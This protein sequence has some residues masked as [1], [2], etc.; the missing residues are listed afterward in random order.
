MLFNRRQPVHLVRRS[1]ATSASVAA[2][3]VTE[4]GEEPKPP[5]ERHKN[6]K[7]KAREEMKSG[8]RTA[9]ALASHSFDVA[10]ELSDA[11]GPLKGVVNGVGYV[12]DIWQVSAYSCD[13]TK[14]IC[15]LIS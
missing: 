10:R 14:P 11:F 4:D 3:E 15:V 8:M 7:K 1:R 13:S 9:S 12:K 2:D 5:P 6:M